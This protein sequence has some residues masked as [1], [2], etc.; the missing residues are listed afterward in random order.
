MD[1]TV[2][3]VDYYD[4][5]QWSRGGPSRRNGGRRQMRLLHNVRFRRVDDLE[6]ILR[7]LRVIEES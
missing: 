5:T 7:S 3:T 1:C 2:M 4:S 6:P